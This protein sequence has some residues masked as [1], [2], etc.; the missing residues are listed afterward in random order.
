MRHIVNSQ[1]LIA[2]FLFAVIASFILLEKEVIACTS[3]IAGKQATE[4]EVILLARNEDYTVTNWNKYLMFRHY[5]AYHTGEKGNPTVGDDNIWTLGNGL[6]VPVPKNE[7]RYSAMPDALGYEEARYSIRDLFYFEERGINERNVAISATNSVEMNDKAKMADDLVAVGIAEAII[8]TLL[9]PQAETALHAVELLGGYVEQYGASEA[10]GILI[11]DSKE[12]WY[13]E[14]GSGHHWIAVKIPADSYLVVANGMRVHGVNLD[15]P[16]VKHS[17]GL[18]EFVEECG[19]L[20]NP[21]RSSFNFA[22]AFGVLGDPYNVDRIWLAQQILTPSKEQQPREEQYP[23][24][25]TPDQK[26]QVQDVMQVLRADYQGTELEN[27]P[28]ATRPIGYVKTVESHVI[29]LDSNM[30]YELQGVIWQVLSTPL[31]APYMPL[32]NVMDDIPPGYAVGGSQYSPF[33]AYWAFRA[34]YVLDTSIY[35]KFWKEYEEQR[36]GEHQYLNQMLKETYKSNHEM[37]IDFAKKYSTGIAY[38]TV[39]I[40][41]QELNRL[42][43]EIVVKQGE[44]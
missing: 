28:K 37:A 34:L 22:K 35:D 16:N 44:E 15:S 8:S 10:N 24:F 23:F 11:G 6:T 17:E 25:L 20:N 36:L 9:L 31:G 13:F 43:T 39:G 30:P 1:Y 3:I 2:Y 26:I 5:P 19:L 18:F 40:A 27:D 21:A 38:Q 33:S 42:A 4:P 7:F 41:N 14:I 32:Y 12:A 29:T